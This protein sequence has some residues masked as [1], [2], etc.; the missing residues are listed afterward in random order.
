MQAL[1][2]NGK[3]IPLSLNKGNTSVLRGSFHSWK[4][5]SQC[6]PLGPR[7][8]YLHI[9]FD[10][11]YNNVGVCISDF[12]HKWYYDLA[13][14]WHFITSSTLRSRC[15][16]N[17][18]F[19]VQ[20][21]D[22]LWT[23]STADILMQMSGVQPQ[24]LRQDLPFKPNSYFLPSNRI[25]CCDL[26]GF[27]VKIGYRYRTPCVM[28]H[29]NFFVCVHTV[30]TFYCSCRAFLGTERNRS[31]SWGSP[32]KTQEPYRSLYQNHYL[33]LANI[34]M[35]MISNLVKH[36]CLILWMKAHC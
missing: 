6:H 8:E 11:K 14:R 15:T 28:V 34:S 21:M 35:K 7:S 36:Y 32:Y 10:L 4:D 5:Y 30:G 2:K 22:L 31:I 25:M 18:E 26:T 19:H 17:N 33:K 27:F 16:E 23:V 1:S 12:V 24:W 3:N 9:N 13:A 29:S 20:N